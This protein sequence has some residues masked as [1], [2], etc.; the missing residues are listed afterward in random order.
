MMHLLHVLEVF[1]EE[2][3]VTVFINW[4]GSARGKET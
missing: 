4:T 3:E 1:L 2:E